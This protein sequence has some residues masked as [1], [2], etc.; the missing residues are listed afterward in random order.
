MESAIGPVQ[1]TLFGGVEPEGEVIK[2]A[3]L[4]FLGTSP[5]AFVKLYQYDE[6]D[7]RFREFDHLAEC[8]IDETETHLS[9]KGCSR[10]MAEELGLPEAES[11]VRWEVDLQGC[12]GCK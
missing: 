5:H 8:V 7:N 10:T 2:R 3:K 4:T 9:I 6:A 12:V 1:V 11:M